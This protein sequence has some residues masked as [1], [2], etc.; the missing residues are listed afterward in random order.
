[1]LLY[2]TLWG[3]ACFPL[4]LMDTATPFSKFSLTL[5][6]IVECWG[7]GICATLAASITDCLLTLDACRPQRRRVFQTLRP[8]VPYWNI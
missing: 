4:G 5:V 6:M 1:M 3:S 2:L 8:E 7:M